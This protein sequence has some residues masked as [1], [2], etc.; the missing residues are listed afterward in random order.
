MDAAEYS[1]R[2]KN[3]NA[4]RSQYLATAIRYERLRA[5]GLYNHPPSE[6]IDGLYRGY[7]ADVE[8][9]INELKL[10]YAN[11]QN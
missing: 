10:E 7:V 5:Q 6:G 4:Q 9:L 8:D 11:S 1:L 3:L 2:L